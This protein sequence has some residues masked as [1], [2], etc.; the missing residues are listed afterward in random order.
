MIRLVNNLKKREGFTLIELMIVVAII[1]ILA[2]IAI[3]N[4]LRFQLRS[5]AGEGKV[6]LAA[7]RT[8]EEGYYAEYS[9]YV[10]TTLQSPVDEAAV[11]AQKNVWT[12]LSGFSEMG[13]EPEGDVY[14]TYA[15]ETNGPG[16]STTPP[17]TE[18]L[19]SAVSDIDADA[20]TELNVWGY[21]KPIP[22]TTTYGGG[23]SAYGGAWG[24]VDTGTYNSQTL[25]QDL[26]ETVGPCAAGNG[27]SR[28]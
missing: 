5:K 15:V 8:A 25:A 16:G 26:L 14:Y 3:P 24:C 1:G 17:F 2:A 22:G 12:D 28:F 13:F 10:Q 18:Y 7:I 9:T 20:A 23:D 6:N 11:G 21:V 4:F 19:A 27:Q